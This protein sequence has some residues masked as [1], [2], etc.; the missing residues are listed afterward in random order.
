MGHLEGDQE[1]HLQPHAGEAAGAQRGGDGPPR[2]GEEQRGDRH[3]EAQ[4][5]QG[6][7]ERAAPE[8]AH[9]VP[10]VGVVAPGHEV[11]VERRGEGDH[12]LGRGQAVGGEPRAQVL[13]AH[14]ARGDPPAL[15]AGGDL[16]VQRG[17]GGDRVLARARDQDGVLEDRAQRA[18]DRGG[19]EAELP[20]GVVLRAGQPEAEHPPGPQ[21]PAHLAEELHRVVAVELDRGGIR[22]R[23]EDRVPAVTAR[24]D[25]PARVAR[26]PSQARILL[27]RGETADDLEHGRIQLDALDRVHRMAGHLPVRA[28]HATRYQQDVLR[29][30]V[31]GQGVV[32]R[33]LG[34]HGIAGGSDGNAVV[35]DVDLPALPRQRQRPVGR[36]ASVDQLQAGEHGPGGGALPVVPG[37]GGAEGRQDQEGDPRQPP[38]TRRHREVDRGE[39]VERRE[40]GR[41]LQRLEEVHQAQAEQRAAHDPPEGVEDVDL[42]DLPRVPALRGRGREHR[43]EEARHQAEGRQE[44]QRGPE[45][46]SDPHHQPGEEELPEQPDAADRERRQDGH[47]ELAG[48]QPAQGI[49]HAPDVLPQ[50]AARA[51]QEQPAREDHAQGELVP[52][53]HAQ[54]LPQGEHLGRDRREPQD[55]RGEEDP[56]PTLL[57]AALVQRI[58]TGTL[59]P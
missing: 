17:V 40:E 51:G 35:P 32:D 15:Q 19:Q 16:Q 57:R 37:H 49:A 18:V 52:R 29:S 7:Q 34:L 55:G 39:P 59:L 11:A 50:E 36:R 56:A 12:L 20:A 47:P 53:E 38:A 46:V 58:P 30:G 4:D 54:E 44:N 26:D 21:R 8:A 31:L 23:H 33:L 28:D 13:L 41:H 10:Q 9:P 43:Q 1:R 25:E 42:P 45:C 48:H 22:E 14:V 6:R 3:R 5:Q 27:R 24:S 2:R